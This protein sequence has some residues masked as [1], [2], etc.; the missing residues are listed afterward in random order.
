[1]QG[2]RVPNGFLDMTYPSAAF[3]DR[4][5]RGSGTSEASAI[6]SG[7]AA[8]VLS[9]YPTA[10]PDMVKK[11]LTDNAVSLYNPAIK[12]AWQGKAQGKGELQMLAMS[13]KKPGSSVQNLNRSTGN[14]SLEITRGT[15][16]LTQDGI[17]LTGQTDIMG[18]GY[19]AAVMAQLIASGRSWSG[20]DWNGRSWSGLAWSGRSWSGS[21]WSGRSWSGNAWDGRSWSGSAWDGDSWS[22]ASWTG[23]SWA[24]AGWY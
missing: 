16:H 2:L 15:D 20:D 10:T 8:V 22:G 18:Q 11:F 9:K 7:A 1:M 5:F 3:G 24:S 19:D 21:D 12:S 23:G 14:G 17:V 13:S 6:V 4:F